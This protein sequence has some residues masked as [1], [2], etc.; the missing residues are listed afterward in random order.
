MCFLIIILYC[1]K[2]YTNCVFE[3]EWH[4]HFGFALDAG[5]GYCFPYI[6]CYLFQLCTFTKNTVSVHL[7]VVLG[8]G[9]VF[10]AQAVTSK[11]CLVPP[12]WT[13]SYVSTNII[14]FPLV[15]STA[16]SM[17]IQPQR[18]LI[19]PIVIILFVVVN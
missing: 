4:H 6:I 15:L 19:L 7:S 17:Q 10:K 3:P 16:T 5:S 1:H 2:K 9:A 11:I 12:Y 18:G 14:R 13:A 8:T